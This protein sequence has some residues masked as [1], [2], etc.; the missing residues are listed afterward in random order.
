MNGTHIPILSPRENPHDYFSYKMKHTL[1]VQVV[2]DHKGTFLDVSV[3]WPGS[4]HNGQV[5]PN[6]RINRML[7]KGELPVLY[8]EILPGYDKVP[9]LLLGDPAFPLL[10]YC[11]KEYPYPRSNKEVILNN[12]HAKKW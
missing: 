6:S 5:F 8:K 11:M 7:S 3:R 10:P 1:N 2:C 12:M 4:V 9:V